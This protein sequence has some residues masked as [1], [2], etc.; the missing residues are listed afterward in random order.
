MRSASHR[1]ALQ[2]PCCLALAT[3]A[4]FLS[5]QQ[6]GPAAR[7]IGSDGR[8]FLET[9][10]EARRIT[11]GQGAAGGTLRLAVTSEPGTLN[12]LSASD[13]V[14]ADISLLLFEGLLA[15]DGASGGLRGALAR[16]WEE[17]PDGRS[18]SARLREG[19]LWSDSTPLTAYDVAYTLG[20]VSG[21]ADG[22]LAGPA[23]LAAICADSLQVEVV[24]SL[25]VRV[26]VARP[27]ALLTRL[28]TMPVLPAHVATGTR[29][30]RAFER[31][32]G[33]R[34]RFDS[35]VVSGPFRPDSWVPTR[36]I[37]LVRNNRY[38]AT[39]VFGA[40]LPYLDTVVVNFVRDH[41]TH[42]VR[43]QRG[44]IDLFSAAGK[45]YALLAQDSAHAYHIYCMG[46]SRA[47]TAML[48][49]QSPGGDTAGE[50]PADS[51]KHSWF[52]MPA[53]RTA[54]SC[55]IDRMGAMDAAGMSGFA[56]FGPVCLADTHLVAAGRGVCRDTTRARRLLAEAGFADRDGD[57][58]V[59]DAGGNPLQFSMLVAAENLPRRKAAERIAEDLLAVGI[60]VN[61]QVAEYQYVMSCLRSSPQAW[62]AALVGLSTPSEPLEAF[63][64][65]HSGGSL[66][67]WERGRPSG[68]QV[69][70][71]SLLDS[72]LRTPAVPQRVR[73]LR[74]WQR[75]FALSVPVVFVCAPER[76]HC[77]SSRLANTVPARL[78]GAIRDMARVYIRPLSADDIRGALAA[79]TAKATVPTQ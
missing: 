46:P 30:D 40:A 26:S 3:V 11:A 19:L 62:E 18:V 79:D 61:V 17:A 42:M 28:L 39:S 13:P 59:E 14:S 34:T 15:V 5:C 60:A 9:L 35:L 70:I 64:L 63:G 57:G 43:F 21:A 52:R 38:H 41:N 12:P 77:V 8:D 69:R 49:N 50:L 55:A 44:E 48:F 68:E 72:A 51:L 56:Q 65:W 10:G 16:S 7:R 37:V 25:T 4:L 66:H 33:L 76:I 27:C 58:V 23:A 20:L 75:Q 29:I 36:R 45:D 78:A 22:V 53:F 1:S 54:V 73:L 67:V 31:F 6:N 74:E 71:D 32:Y 24:D 2:V 47:P